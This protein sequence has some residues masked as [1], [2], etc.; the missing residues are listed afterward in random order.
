LGFPA[1]IRLHLGPASIWR[2]LR[3][4][5][6]RRGYVALPEWPLVTHCYRNVTSIT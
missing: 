6:L 3:R 5:A 4:D 1:A 2:G